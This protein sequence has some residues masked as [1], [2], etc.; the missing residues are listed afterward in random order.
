MN[1]KKYGLPTLGSSKKWCKNNER[2]RYVSTC[3]LNK[4][5]NKALF[6]FTLIKFSQDT[7]VHQLITILYFNKLI[8]N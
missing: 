7:L 6:Q 2:E 8:N 1:G 4:D 5:I 3:I